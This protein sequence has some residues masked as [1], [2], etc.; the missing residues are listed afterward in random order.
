VQHGC[1]A[2][3]GEPVTGC[4]CTQLREEPSVCTLGS[5]RGGG[6]TPSCE[7]HAG[8]VTPVQRTLRGACHRLHLQPTGR[9]SAPSAASALAV[10]RLTRGGLGS[11]GARVT[12]V[13]CRPLRRDALQLCVAA[14]NRPPALL[15]SGRASP[16]QPQG[17]AASAREGPRPRP[18]GE[19]AQSPFDCG[20]NPPVAWHGAW[21]TSPPRIVCF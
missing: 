19:P 12:C 4:T 5:V 6:R 3:Y 11:R 2:P 20:D 16:S 13:G 9:V 18:R 15:S 8:G 17:P 21:L 1:G 10:G 14:Q 7:S